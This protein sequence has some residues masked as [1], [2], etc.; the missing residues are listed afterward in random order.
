MLF[1]GPECTHMHQNWMAKPPVRFM[2][3]SLWKMGKWNSMNV[4]GKKKKGRGQIDG[5]LAEMAEAKQMPLQMCMIWVSKRFASLM[6]HTGNVLL[7]LDVLPTN[8]LWMPAKTANTGKDVFF[9]VWKSSAFV[10]LHRPFV[11]PRLVSIVFV[12]HVRASSS[13]SVHLPRCVS[14][15]T[16]RPFLPSL[17]TFSWQKV[18]RRNVH[19][20]GSVS[21]IFRNNNKTQSA[22][23]FIDY[24][25]LKLVISGGYGQCTDLGELLLYRSVQTVGGDALSAVNMRAQITVDAMTVSVVLHLHTTGRTDIHAEFIIHKYGNVVN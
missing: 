6:F 3:I 10:R 14:R 2:E 24:S 20:S 16:V 22:A 12:F 11:L 18:Q 1:S 19:N 21:D 15:P 25:S 13:P 23:V 5:D 8:K 9:A 7:G 17:T 4:K